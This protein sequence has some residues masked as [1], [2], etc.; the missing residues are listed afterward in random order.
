MAVGNPIYSAYE[1][2][3]FRQ[4]R[5]KPLPRHVGVMLDG[6]RRWARLRGADSAEGHQAGA[7]NIANLL[8]WC[9]EVG[10][11]VVTLW[12][13][14]TDNL[15]RDHEELETLLA[16]IE[17]VVA[18]LAET[19][20]WRI[21]PVGALELLPEATVERLNAAAAATSTVD[22]LLPGAGATGCGAL[23]RR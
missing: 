4:L 3:L 5:D 23:S 8:T 2:R 15:S 14:S 6:N 19:R 11:E 12:L 16:I 13:L 17:K 20:R 10:V 21:N 9:E 22:G 18:E 1:R 7:D